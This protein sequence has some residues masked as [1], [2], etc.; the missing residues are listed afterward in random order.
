MLSLLLVAMT[1]MFRTSRETYNCSLTAST[2]LSSIKPQFIIYSTINKKAT[3]TWL[4]KMKL[5]KHVPTSAWSTIK[6]KFILIKPINQWWTTSFHPRQILIIYRKFLKLTSVWMHTSTQL[7]SNSSA[8]KNQSQWIWWEREE[9]R[10]SNCRAL[11]LK[12]RI[13]SQWILMLSS[14]RLLH[15]SK[16]L[17]SIL[18]T[19][20]KAYSFSIW[21]SS[22]DPE[23]KSISDR[24]VTFPSKKVR[25]LITN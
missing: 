21:N 17:R 9:N 5:Q 16:N 4:L 12:V 10:E 6:I 19:Q 18:Q 8:T 3:I 23:H 24:L 7:F 20:E 13:I 1:P 15:N 25:R 22:Q 14:K 11:K 2:L